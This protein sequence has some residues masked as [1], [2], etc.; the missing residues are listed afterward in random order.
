MTVYTDGRLKRVVGRFIDL[1]SRPRYL[2]DHFS[3]LGDASAGSFDVPSIAAS[4]I[5]TTRTRSAPAV[6]TLTPNNLVLDQEPALKSLLPHRDR[7]SLLEGNYFESLA[8]QK[9]FEIRNSIDN[10]L[11]DQLW[12]VAAAAAAGDNS[13]AN[14][15]GNVINAALAAL[16]LSL[17]G[18]TEAAL[19]ANGYQRDHFMWALSPKAFA[20]FRT[21]SDVVP[22]FSRAEMSDLGVP[23]S[24]PYITVHGIPCIETPALPNAIAVEGDASQSSTTITFVPDSTVHGLQTGMLATTDSAT[25]VDATA[26]AITVNAAGDSITM[27]ADGSATVSSESATVNVGAGVGVLFDR[28]KAFYAGDVV[29]TVRV[30]PDS[31]SMSDVLQIGAKYGKFV[32]GGAARTLLVP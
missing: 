26:S 27:A 15:G 8:D 13:A 23:S 19:V 5:G 25:I 31:E 2:S 7:E 30:V 32:Y 12:K 9:F 1:A 11:S 4:T 3:Y 16:A 6:D 24:A 29:P 17:I 21:L 10:D 20:K 28:T 18:D 22:S 14:D